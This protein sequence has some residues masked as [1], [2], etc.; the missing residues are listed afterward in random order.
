MVW[1]AISPWV[2]SL[3][4]VRQVERNGS[5]FYKTTPE[6]DALHSCVED[7]VFSI[8]QN[9]TQKARESIESCSAEDLTNPLFDCLRACAHWADGDEEAAVAAT[10]SARLKGT[11]RIY[12]SSALDPSVWRWA[13]I[14]IICATAKEIGDS[15]PSDIRKL[16][17]SLVMSDLVVWSEPADPR[18]MLHGLAVRQLMARRMRNTAGA[19]GD[20]KLVGLADRLLEEGTAF[21]MAVNEAYS[22]DGPLA[23]ARRAWMV[24]RTFRDRGN[25]SDA[26]ALLV[27]D[28]SAKWAEN[29]RQETMSAG[30]VDQIVIE[31]QNRVSKRAK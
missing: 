10:S 25:R 20:Q 28:E 31:T 13:E 15:G 6:T 4:A 24:D 5:Q 19:A 2:S 17:A 8:R 1:G 9:E 11:L 18:R 29:C 3:V 26:V 23:V 27:M 21:R 16:V 12:P 14:D 7:I 22:Q 30:L